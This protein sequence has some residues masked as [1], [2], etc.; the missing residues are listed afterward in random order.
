MK[1]IPKM[2]VSYPQHQEIPSRAF[3]MVGYTMGCY[4]KDKEWVATP[5]TNWAIVIVANN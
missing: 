1:H 5:N 3:V 2:Y 4:E